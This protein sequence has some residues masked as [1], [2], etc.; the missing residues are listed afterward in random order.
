L[1]YGNIGRPIL[2]ANFSLG[3]LPIPVAITLCNR[4]G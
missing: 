4:L 2:E 3:I 1:P